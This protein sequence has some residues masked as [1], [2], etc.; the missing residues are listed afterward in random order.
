MILPMKLLIID[1]HTILR[2][3]VAEI[4]R[5]A[6]PGTD[7]LEASSIAQGLALADQHPDL[8]AILLDLSFPGPDGLSAITEFRART[9]VAILVLSS[10]EDPADVRQALAKGARG[11]VTKSASAQTL[12]SA[13]QLILAGEIYVPPLLAE[14]TA[15]HHPRA[16][17]T[18]RQMDVLIAVCGGLS[19]KDIGQKLDMS[20]KTVKVHVSAIF[21]ALNVVN[22]TQA[23]IAARTAGLVSVK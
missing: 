21:R 12:V 5:Q 22:R 18:Q 3:G 13:L 15:T 6:Q 19:N 16:T 10:S 14:A 1:D 2:A 4:L 11:Y 20:E 23:V 7:V 9:P 17:L 8:S